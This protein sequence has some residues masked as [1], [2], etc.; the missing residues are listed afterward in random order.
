[1]FSVLCFLFCLSTL[2]TNVTGGRQT[3]QKTQCCNVS[4]NIID[5]PETL[6][7][8]GTSCVWCP[9]LPKSLDCLL[10]F[11]W[12]EDKQR[13][14]MLQMSLDRKH[15]RQSRDIGNIG[16]QTQEEDKQN[17]K[18]NTE[19]I[20][21]NPETLAT[22][23]TRHSIWKTNKVKKH[24]TENIIDNPETLATLGTMFSG[25]RQAIKS[26]NTEN[27]IDNP[28]TLATLGTSHRRKTNKTNVATL[29]T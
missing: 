1:M 8:L 10:C 26:Y 15:N 5:N 3:K 4:E 21:D 12:C 24:N 23:G 19:N 28:E 14:Q 7:T 29:K 11:L 25:G 20:I 6:A 13:C 16:H 2:G 22:L 9:M 17:K 18:H 27:I